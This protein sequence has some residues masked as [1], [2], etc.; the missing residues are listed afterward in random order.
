MNH[1][2]HTL[3]E[4][5]AAL[6]SRPALSV[7]IEGGWFRDP[8]AVRRR[9]A[10]VIA[11]IPHPPGRK[12]ASALRWGES[13]QMSSLS[14]GDIQLIVQANAMCDW[15]VYAL[16]CADAGEIPPVAHTVLSQ[17]A[18]WPALRGRRFEH[19][20]EAAVKGLEASD[21][22]GLRAL[23]ERCQRQYPGARQLGQSSMRE[24]P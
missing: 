15:I 23:V 16:Q 12:R 17:L 4:K 8:D 2:D 18:R 1:D 5:S 3:T 21:L 6:A 20:L 13:E 11:E 19:E 24:N 22:T 9:A 14:E 10:E 7:G